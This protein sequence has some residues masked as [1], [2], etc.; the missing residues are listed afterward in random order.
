VG[1]KLLQSIGLSAPDDAS[2]QAAIEANDAFVGRLEAVRD[3]AQRLTI[4]QD[5]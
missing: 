3:A 1:R 5:D 2:I 4:D